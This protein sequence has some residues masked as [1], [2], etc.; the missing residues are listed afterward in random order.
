MRHTLN[1]PFVVLLGLYLMS[2]G[3]TNSF[4]K[5]L[6]NILHICV[7]LT[8]FRNL[9][10]NAEDCGDV[11]S[12][13][14]VSLQK[15]LLCKYD[16]TNRPVKNHNTA[17]NVTIR[18]LLRGLRYSS[19]VSFDKKKIRVNFFELFLICYNFSGFIRKSSIS[20]VG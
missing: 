6:Y 17:V 16:S 20:K 18:M 1:V 7:S 9:A 15:K 10:A 11:D 8:L 12:S 3:I 2:N 14:E 5:P 4:I 13:F 19:A